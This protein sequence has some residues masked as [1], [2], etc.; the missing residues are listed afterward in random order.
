MEHNASTHFTEVVIV[1]IIP[2]KTQYLYWQ[3]HNAPLSQRQRQIA[4]SHYQICPDGLSMHTKLSKLCRETR[5][6][7]KWFWPTKIICDRRLS[8][9][10]RNFNYTPFHF[11]NQQIFPQDRDFNRFH[12]PLKPIYKGIRTN[13]PC[14]REKTRIESKSHMASYPRPVS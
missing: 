6:C 11:C 12:P 14:S 4:M 8:A 9:L 3:R 1:I 13:C 2:V 10:C 7:A 5:N